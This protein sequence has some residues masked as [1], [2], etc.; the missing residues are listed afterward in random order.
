MRIRQLLQEQGVELGLPDPRPPRPA[1]A[2]DIDWRVGELGLGW[3]D[4]RERFVVVVREVPAEEGADLAGARFWLTQQQ[5]VRFSRRPS[6][7]SPRV[8]RSAPTA[9]CPSTREASV[10]RGQ[11]VS[12]RLL[13]RTR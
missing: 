11:W 4:R 1:E 2:S 3:H 10:P 9:A 12:T 8:A 5:V 13:S 7:S 6:R